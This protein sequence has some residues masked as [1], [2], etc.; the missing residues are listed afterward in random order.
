MRLPVNAENGESNGTVPRSHLPFLAGP[1]P[2]AAFREGRS[3]VVPG[4]NQHAQS[5][6]YWSA[7]VC[8]CSLRSGQ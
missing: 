7:A 2:G 3:G 5:C 6:A 1:N 4:L 8:F